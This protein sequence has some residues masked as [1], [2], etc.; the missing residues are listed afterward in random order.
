MTDAWKGFER[1]V[2]ERFKSILA[3][4]GFKELVYELKRRGPLTADSEHGLP[5]ITAPGLSVECKL[6]KRMGYAAILDA[7]RQAKADRRNETDIPLAV[8]K[9]YGKGR[10]DNDALVCFRLEDFEE[11]F[12]KEKANDL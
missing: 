7:C 11:L 3:D 9:L 6:Y 12:R 4:A 8:V 2:A 1:R 5:D 10:P